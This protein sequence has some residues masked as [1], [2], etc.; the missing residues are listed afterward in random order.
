M[1]SLDRMTSKFMMHLLDEITS[2][3]KEKDA[4]IKVIKKLKTKVANLKLRKERWT[5][6]NG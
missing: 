3:R 6:H 5:C 2:L 4:Q 1:G